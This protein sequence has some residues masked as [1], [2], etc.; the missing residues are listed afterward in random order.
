MRHE[1]LST[2]RSGEWTVKARTHSQWLQ[3]ELLEVSHSHGGLA[4]TFLKT[5]SNETGSNKVRGDEMAQILS[6]MSNGIQAQV[7]LG[8]DA[9]RIFA[10]SVSCLQ[11]CK[12][13][14]QPVPEDVHQFFVHLDMICFCALSLTGVHVYDPVDWQ[15]SRGGVVQNVR[16]LQPCGLSGT[17]RGCIS[18]FLVGTQVLQSKLAHQLHVYALK[19]QAFRVPHHHNNFRN[20]RHVVS[21]SKRIDEMVI[22]FAGARVT[23]EVASALL[24]SCLERQGLGGVR[25]ETIG[26][27]TCNTSEVAVQGPSPRGDCFA[28][29]LASFDIGVV[30][31]QRH[32]PGV[33]PETATVQT[34][35][36]EEKP[37]QRL[38]NMLAVG[39]PTVAYAGYAGHQE[40]LKDARFHPLVENATELCAEVV[41][42]LKDPALRRSASHEALELAVPYSPK[43][44]G[45]LYIESFRILQ[46]T[47]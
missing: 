20:R 29:K 6:N 1:Q 10:E 4:V 30:W 18:A 47:A 37:P 16:R 12:R 31:Q 36:N 33:R 17:T 32:L 40:I 19:A 42:L 34:T 24:S 35:G 45:A 28:M 39:L 22:G 9:A 8:K 14:Q 25:I 7:L 43:R 38:L 23:Q 15:L 5:A 44:V 11:Y 3:S 46:S 21:S 2:T 41:K 27:M 26:N 13:A